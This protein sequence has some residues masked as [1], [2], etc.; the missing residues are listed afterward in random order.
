MYILYDTYS[1]HFIGVYSTK[2]KANEVLEWMHKDND[3]I[4]DEITARGGY[5]NYRQRRKL[6]KK[7][8]NY[9]Y[10]VYRTRY[11]FI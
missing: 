4:V 5:N 1:H 7:F 6:A 10:Y 11:K 8:K 9:S 3:R 2:E